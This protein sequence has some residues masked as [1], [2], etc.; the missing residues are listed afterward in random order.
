MICLFIDTS[1]IDVSIGLI[2]DNKILSYIT[3]SVPNKHS[4]YTTSYLDKV[5]KNANIKV[6]DIDKI[7]VVNGPGSFTGIRIGVTIAKVYAYLTNCE[8]VCLSSLKV[9]SLSTNCENTYYMSL[10]DAKHDNYYVGLYDK[11]Y[12]DIIEK[13]A[14]ADEIINYI[15]EYN[16]VIVSNKKFTIDKYIVSK[17]ELDLIKIANYYKNIPTMNPHFVNPNYLKLPQVL[18]SKND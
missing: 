7:L 5:I 15:K 2:K 13:F 18:E 6:T 10:I 17:V 1:D 11:D 14:S 16:P 4:V 8:I 3:K 12:N 9:L